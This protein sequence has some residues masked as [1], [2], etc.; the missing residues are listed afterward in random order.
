MSELERPSYVPENCSIEF[1]YECVA[2]FWE[3]SARAALSGLLAGQY[4]GDAVAAAGRFADSLVTEWRLR[5]E[6][7]RENTAVTVKR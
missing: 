4:D 3:R 5:F 6:K 1:N 7:S 2:R